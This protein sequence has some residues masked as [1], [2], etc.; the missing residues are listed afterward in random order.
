MGIFA[1]LCERIFGRRSSDART[2]PRLD[3]MAEPDEAPTQQLPTQQ[4]PVALVVR[5]TS[6]ALAKT[7]T[8]LTALAPPVDV[9]LDDALLF[10]NVAKV[11]LQVRTSL[12]PPQRSSLPPALATLDDD[13]FAGLPEP[14]SAQMAA[15]ESGVVAAS[16]PSGAPRALT[17]SESQV[18]MRALDRNNTETRRVEAVQL[19]A[20]ARMSPF[21]APTRRIDATELAKALDARANPRTKTKP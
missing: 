5:R 7:R 6:P 9:V 20:G 11:A 21:D 8:T 16:S 3:L 15:A 4:L 12:P 14:A 17:K 19:A 1:K 2:A 13:P 18:R 10:E